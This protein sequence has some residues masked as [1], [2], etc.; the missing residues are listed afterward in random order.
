[1][2]TEFSPPF[3]VAYC[4]ITC[5]G[6]PDDGNLSRV[7]SMSEVELLAF[8]EDPRSPLYEASKEEQKEFPAICRLSGRR[9]SCILLAEK[10]SYSYSY[11]YQCVKLALCASGQASVCG[12]HCIPQGCVTCTSEKVA[13]VL[14]GDEANYL[15]TYVHVSNR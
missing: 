2:R 12:V 6:C 5:C 13:K 8:Q 11:T 1:M 10:G 7:A 14:L 15:A 9:V 4:A 3:Y